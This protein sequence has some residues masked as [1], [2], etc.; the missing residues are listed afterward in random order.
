MYFQMKKV[1]PMLAIL[2]LAA[3]CSARVDISVYLN[4]MVYMQY[5]PVYACIT[6]RNDSGRSLLFGNDPRLQGTIQFDIRDS[7]GRAV[8]K[9]PGRE[10]D[11][12]GLVLAPGE[13]KNM[14]IPIQRYYNLDRLGTY[15]IAAYISHNLL[16]HEYQ[17]RDKIFR[18]EQG[19]EVWKRTVGI[20]DLEGNSPDKVRHRTYVLRTLTESTSKYYYLAVEDEKNIY[21]VMRVGQVVGREKYQIEVDMLSRI[22]LLIPLSPRIFHYLSFSL[23]GININNSYWRTSETIPMLHRDSKTGIVSR[24][25]G[26]EARPGVDFK[27]PNAGKLTAGKLLDANTVE[28]RPAPTP[29]KDS[30]IIDIGKKLDFPVRDPE[31]DDD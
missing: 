17:S 13:I 8:E 18:V 15:R 31:K 21:G 28:A 5:E 25:G 19:V 1:L 6:L 9:I 23:D 24:I 4:R 26:V 20:P 22:H 12:T 30:G 11:V 14:V 7:S 29:V 27:D 3:T 2:L 16:A 10:I